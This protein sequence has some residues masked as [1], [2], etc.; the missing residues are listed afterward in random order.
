MGPDGMTVGEQLAAISTRVHELVA[1]QS[2]GLAALLPKLAEA[3][4]VFVKPSELSAA[5]ARRPRRALP[6]RGLPDPH[7]DRDRPGPPVPAG[8]QQEPEPRRHVHARG[9]ARARASASCRC[10]RCCRASSRSSGV[11]TPTGS[12]RRARSCCSRTS[13]AARRDDLPGRAHPGPLRLPRHAQL[14]HRGRR[15]GGRRPPPVD[16]AGAPA[17]RAR[18]RGAPR[19]RRATPPAGSL[20]KL[21]K[22]LKLDPEK[23]VYRVAR[24]AQRRRTS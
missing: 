9:L 3:G 19:G 1:A 11:K 17:A 20:A 24:H 7:A 8:A 5:G 2:Q 4:I 16:P 21:V 6:Q 18:Q 10:R 12:R 23:D 15:G 14:R 13:R 22:A